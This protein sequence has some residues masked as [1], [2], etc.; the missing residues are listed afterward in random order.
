MD[1]HV[2]KQESFNSIHC[3]E[4]GKAFSQPDNLK[5]HMLETHQ[6]GSGQKRPAEDV[7]ESANGSV[8]KRLRKEDDP[9]DFYSISKVKEQRMVKFKTT[10]STYEVSIK[11]LEVTEDV[12]STLKRIFT[13]IFQDLTKGATSEDLLRLVVQSPGLDYAIVTPFLKVT[14][15]TADRFMSEH[16][17]VL[18]SNEDFVIDSGLILEVTQVDMPKVV[19]ENIANL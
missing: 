10:A 9:R 4:C 2:E 11:D 18:Q 16:E 5:R 8:T 19:Q 12:P 13:S 1:R 6:V 7:E 3:E 14:G 15:L 17:R